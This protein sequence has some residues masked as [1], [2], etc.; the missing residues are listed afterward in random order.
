MDKSTE[1]DRTNFLTS[2]K[3]KHIFIGITFLMII[4]SIKF[5]Y[6]IK[7]EIPLLN[8]TVA[9][10][11][12]K[13]I[14]IILFTSTKTTS[15]ASKSLPSTIKI[16]SKIV[17]SDET[18]CDNL[19]EYHPNNPCERIRCA[20]V[21]RSSGG[22]LGN[23]MFMFASAYGL[24]RTQNCHLYVSATIRNE[25]EN[26]FQMKPIDEKIWLSEKKLGQLTNI[27]IRDTVCSFLPELIR[28]NAFKNIELHGYWQS[29]LYFDA[30][31]E[32]IRKIFSARNDALVRLAKYFTDL[33]NSICSLCSPLPDKTHQELR[34]AFQTR[35]NITWISI[36]IRRRDF[37]G[38][39][40]SSDESYIHRA[41]IFFRRRYYQNHVRFLVASDD[42][43]YC[44]GLFASE[45]KSGRIIILPDHFSPTDDL[46]ALSLCHHSIVTG[47]T[48][49]FWSAYLAGGEVIH[50]IK[51]KTGCLR[52]D[53][54]PPWFILAGSVEEKKV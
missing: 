7:T 31:R 51:Y 26:N 28:P 3:K 50:D 13:S 37:L 47:G 33:T 41:I 46:M 12:N 6:S 52:S 53:Y 10:Q 30:Y 15:L 39:R 25:L 38:L 8:I 44:R 23:R 40:Y 16:N 24:A 43:N 14:Q 54:Y 42:R 4:S 34:Q 36:H 32:E 48:F 11:M 2:I 35:Y 21:L 18:L 5:F 22:R 19:T 27:R 20:I 49:G 1:S 17:N 9:K 45:Q 29:Y